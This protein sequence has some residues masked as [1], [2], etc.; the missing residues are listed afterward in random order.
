MSRIIL[1]NFAARLT[2]RFQAQTL[3]YDF[4]A[5]GHRRA[6]P[7]AQDM[8]NGAQDRDGT[9][10]P[11]DDIAGL[12]KLE[13]FLGRILRQLRLVDLPAFQQR[14]AAFEVVMNGTVLNTK[15]FREI[16]LYQLAMNDLE[17]Q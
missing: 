12:G 3:H 6:Y 2:G 8:R 4:L 7:H 16:A 13:N 14:R 15:P 17:V 11:D 5:E 1:L 10:T 9:P